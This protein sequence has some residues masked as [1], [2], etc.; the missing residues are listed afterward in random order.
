MMRKWTP[1]RIRC[2]RCLLDDVATYGKTRITIAPLSTS[3]RSQERTPKPARNSA[4]PLVKPTSVSARPLVKPAHIS[5]RPLE[6]RFSIHRDD[7]EK[8]FGQQRLAMSKKGIVDPEETQRRVQQAVEGCIQRM[9]INDLTPDNS[10]MSEGDLAIRKGAWKAFQAEVLAIVR[11]N[12]DDLSEEDRAFR[13]DLLYDPNSASQAGKDDK[14]QPRIQ[15]LLL[16]RYFDRTLSSAGYDVQA[17]LKK[18]ADMRYPGEW[19]VEARSRQRAIHL[20]IGPTNSGKTYNALK[21]LEQAGSGFYAGPLRLLAHEVYSRFRA[22]G[23]PCNL[24]TGDDVRIEDD[25][26]GATLSASTVEMVN[27]GK[28]VDVAVIDEIQMMADSERGWAWTR[29][30]MGAVAKEVHLCGEE[31]VLPLIRE[32]A[33]TMGDSLE[34]H[35]YQRLN[36]LKCMRTSLN[37]DLSLLQKGDAVVCFSVVNI[38]AF[39][40]AIEKLTGKRVAIVYGSL[41]PETRAQQAALFNDP[42]NDYDFLVASDAIGMGLNLSIKRIVFSTVEKYN[43]STWEQLPIPQIKQIAGRAGRYRTAHQATKNV[44]DSVLR[45]QGR[46]A[47]LVTTLLDSDLPI[48]RAA[49]EAEAPPITTAGLLPP[50]DFIEEFASR[51]PADTP[52]QYLLERLSKAASLHPRFLMC[53][54]TQQ[55]Q[56]AHIIEPI[57]GITTTDRHILTMAPFSF[58]QQYQDRGMDLFRELAQ[59]VAD[60][61]SITPVDLKS[62]P[63]EILQEPMHPA[64]QFLEELEFLHQSFILYIWLSYRMGST[65]GAQSMAFHAK[66]MTEAR[67]NACLQRY[68][69][70]ESAMKGRDHRREETENVVKRPVRIA[71]TRKPLM[72]DY[73]NTGGNEIR[74]S[75]TRPALPMSWHKRD[76]ELPAK[77]SASRDQIL[78]MLKKVRSTSSAAGN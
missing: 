60:K 58:R 40:K 44:A 68:S 12:A 33:A 15:S 5:A 9:G 26:E 74:T 45:E 17:T 20:H 14:R 73:D 67:I 18:V 64:R 22:K 47:G 62:M 59:A 48:V 36:P 3:A 28:A 52:H 10:S 43:G 13:H 25:G 29:A 21:R 16:R 78:S 75:S 49:L 55:G 56:L 32:L 35:R 39:K 53:N 34:V 72:H 69:S 38:H 54:L 50:G 8:F 23:L 30:F 24:I 66:E 37:E 71:D 19:F 46:S 31:R 11:G 41:P 2:P 27:T 42:D 61:R 57:R 1:Q 77:T 4:R 63:L 65:M 51:L 70:A 76:D 6:D 7:V